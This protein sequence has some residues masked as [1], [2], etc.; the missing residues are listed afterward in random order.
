MLRLL[1][2]YAGAWW[3]LHA[4][5]TPM[6]LSTKYEIE[7]GVFP[8][9]SVPKGGAQRPSDAAPRPRSPIPPCFWDSG[10]G[11]RMRGQG[12]VTTAP[13]REAKGALAEVS[14]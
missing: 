9:K 10:G 2:P 7:G 6:L 4:H 8:I 12:K 3:D 13:Q 14:G 11:A 1:D 5:S